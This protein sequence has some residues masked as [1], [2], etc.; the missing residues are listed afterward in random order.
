MQ[1]YLTLLNKIL[2]EGE[3]RGDR[4]GTGTLSIFGY[5]DRY[6]L[7]AG[8]PAVTTKKLAFK[9]MKAELLW[10]LEGSNDERRLAEITHGTSD[11]KT[12][13][14]TPNA[15]APYWKDKA[16]FEGDLG[17]V[18]GKQMRDWRT[19]LFD[20]TDNLIGYKSTDQI[21][22]LVNGI[23]ADPTSRRHMLVNY[24]PGELDN[25]ALPACHSFAQFYVSNDGKLSCQYYMRSNDVLLGKPFNDAS[26]ALLTHMLAQVCDLEVGE[27]IFTIGDAHLYQNHIEQAKEQLTKEPYPLPKLLLN[28]S[29]KDI[30]E[31]KMDDIQLLDYKHHPSI[32][33]DM[34]V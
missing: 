19:P 21:T 8:F 5:Q 17:R 29:V 15:Q 30:F 11:G 10:F 7:S 12:T 9:S 20:D 6:D 33:A 31:F 18:Y 2:T 26:Y 34:A 1:Q 24:N 22:N 28:E 4:T 3:L 32:K 14:W 27:L 16:K 25:M 23:K 13:I